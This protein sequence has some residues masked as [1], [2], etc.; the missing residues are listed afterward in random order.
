MTRRVSFSPD[1]DDMPSPPPLYLTNHARDNLHTPEPMIRIWTF[2]S[3][4]SSGFSAMR[5]LGRIKAKFARALGFVSSSR[6]LSSS[7]ST[8]S[9]ECTLK[10]SRS[11][12]EAFDSNRAQAI[13]DCI[14]FLNSSSTSSFQ[15]SKSVSY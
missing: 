6:K 8:S 14:Q 2:R 10:R 7:S 5:F 13:E 15:R 12:V 3:Q 9:C 11:Y 1:V 4:K